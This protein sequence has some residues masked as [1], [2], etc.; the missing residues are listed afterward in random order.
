MRVLVTGGGGFLGSCIAKKLHAR[1]DQVIV[2]GRNKYT[3]LDSGIESIAC[4]IRDKAGVS[5]ALKGCDAVFH[6]AAIPGV[7][8]DYEKYNG[9]NVEGTR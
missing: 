2:L 4:D 6:A 5:L 7:W 8:G 9:I 3:H 1:G